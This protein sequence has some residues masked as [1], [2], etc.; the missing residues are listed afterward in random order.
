MDLPLG[1]PFYEHLKTKDTDMLKMIQELMQKEFT[2]YII[3]TIDGYNGIEEGALLFRKGVL[4][5]AG[6]E[7]M[8]H[9]I[10]VEGNKAL[11]IVLNAFKAK[12]GII[13]VYTLTLQHMDLVIAFHEKMLIN[14]KI[15]PK[16]LQKMYPKEFSD[17]Y[18]KDIIKQK[19]ELSKY[20]IFRKVGLPEIA[21]K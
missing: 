20:D 5:G 8:K 13:D 14:V 19:E 7:F 6:Y 10:V 4:I 18:A 21:G 3:V 16:T 9:D 11:G 15:E 2:G 17:K 1:T 12:H